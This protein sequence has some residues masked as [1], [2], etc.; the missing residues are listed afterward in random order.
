[1]KQTE[2]TAVPIWVTGT[3]LLSCA[4]ASP[5][6]LWNSCIDGKTGIANGLGTI[7]DQTV[8]DLASEQGL[9]SLSIPSILPERMPKPIF[10]A[11]YAL[12]QAMQEA[13]WTDLREDDGLI[14]ATTTG[15][16]S[17]WDTALIQ[18]LNQSVSQQEFEEHFK[19]QPLGSVLSALCELVG[20]RGKRTLVTSACSA[21][22]QAIALATLWLKQGR[23][24]RCIVGGSE[25]LC[26]LTI[27]GFR[28]LQLL[29]SDPTTP[30]DVNRKG[31]N[32]S[33]GAGF[34]CLE[35]TQGNAQPLAKISGCAL[36]TDGYHMTAPHPEGEGCLRA[37][38]LAIKKSGITPS[39][40]DW[41][42]SHG[43]GSLHNDLA[44]G[45]AI[46]QLFQKDLPWV[47]ST[48]WVHGHALG[49]SGV[50]E[51]ILCTQALKHQT[52]LKT[53]GLQT[54][55]PKILVRHPSQSMAY[56]IRHILKNTLGFGGANAALVISHPEIGQS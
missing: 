12:T 45:A 43:T 5:T 22:S 52:I 56:P 29:S 34:L 1:M 54:A 49:A 14:F 6:E 7:S 53:W 10:L 18:F 11:W 51:T 3:G 27:D 55:D 20:F 26:R 15:Q 37:M 32:L 19:K 50:I 28:S 23:V 16:I 13:G 39:E 36:T 24:K 33:E 44:E 31:I 38:T 46:H 2:K 42:H 4:G 30:F 17:A 40:I 35:T 21:S 41:V 8:F 48:K 47:S 9:N 25:I